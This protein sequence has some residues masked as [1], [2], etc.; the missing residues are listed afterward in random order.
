M[1]WYRYDCSWRSVIFRWM[2]FSPL[3]DLAAGPEPNGPEP[4][5][6][7]GAF[8]NNEEVAEMRSSKQERSSSWC[9][10]RSG[11]RI[12]AVLLICGVLGF[13]FHNSTNLRNYHHHIRVHKAEHDLDVPIE[14]Q[15]VETRTTDLGFERV[16]SQRRGNEDSS[17]LDKSLPLVQF[18]DSQMPGFPV[19]GA[20]IEAADALTCRKSVIGYVVDATDV[21][22]ECEGLTKAFEKTCNGAAAPPPRKS[23]KKPKRASKYRRG[24][25]NNKQTRK[26]NHPRKLLRDK[27]WQSYR[28]RAW[29]YE[30][31][32][33]LKRLKDYFLFPAS[34]YSFNAED[35]VAGEAYTDACYAVDGGFDATVHRGLRKHFMA[36]LQ[37]QRR[38]LEEEEE[39]LVRNDE[40]EFTNDTLA[41]I[42]VKKPTGTLLLNTPNGMVSDMTLDIINKVPDH[43]TTAIATE[44]DEEED[45]EVANE[46]AA[47]QQKIEVRD[48]EDPTII[49]AKPKSIEEPYVPGSPE[50]KKCC[51]SIL[52]VYQKNCSVEPEEDVSDSRLFFVICVMALC[53]MVKSI[54]RHFKILWL[55][56]AAGCILVGGTSL[57]CSLSQ[58]GGY[59]Q[60]SDRCSLFHPQF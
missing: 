45:V 29:L 57:L 47:E 10:C 20:P 25:N 39:V 40:K 59:L 22:D 26:H 13:Y 6:S 2:S 21:K 54:I 55:P 48:P 32:I 53:L 60:S 51:M 34:R 9:S 36:V 11:S 23:S 52:N 44:E 30:H 37:K 27:I 41:P 38:K 17:D 43:N 46:V 31:Y 50:L 58:T 7:I 16:E 1:S 8:M 14:S 19:L 5:G 4:S 35:A 15:Q 33:W 28:W 56:E 42:V 3:A 49:E 24:K 12:A 18:K